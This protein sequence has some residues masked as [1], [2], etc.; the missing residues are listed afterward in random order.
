M[1]KQTVPVPTVKKTI[2]YAGRVDKYTQWYYVTAE[3]IAAPCTLSDENAVYF[4]AKAGRG[5]IIGG[6]YTVDAT[7]DGR[8]I[9]L[10]TMRFASM[11]PIAEDCAKWHVSTKYAARKQRAAKYNP[12]IELL[13]PILSV[14]R[15]LNGEERAILLTQVV[16]AFLRG[17]SL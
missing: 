9:V 4:N 7:E 3:L 10:A 1:T 13:E 11:W 15:R 12:V 5:K 6:V 2:V 17:G 16:Q 8:T 14:Y